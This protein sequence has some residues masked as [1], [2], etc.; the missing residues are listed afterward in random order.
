MPTRD[1]VS[2]IF[3]EKYYPGCVLGSLVSQLLVTKGGSPRILVLVWTSF[4]ASYQ[5]VLAHVNPWSGNDWPRMHC[6][7]NVNHAQAFLVPSFRRVSVQVGMAP[8]P[9]WESPTHNQKPL[10]RMTS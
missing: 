9:L 5:Q 7:P 4:S 10:I 8:G 3:G 2:R 6:T 1:Q